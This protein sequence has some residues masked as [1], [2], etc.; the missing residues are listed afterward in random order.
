MPNAQTARYA[1][2]GA[3]AMPHNEPAA[4]IWDRGGDAYDRIS[5]GVSDALAHAAQ[6]L[7][8]WPRPRRGPPISTRRSPSSKRMPR[9]CPSP[10]ASSTPSSRPSG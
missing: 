4:R 9:P 8:F 10:M 1:A 7:N 5:F 3:A 2:Q 6:R